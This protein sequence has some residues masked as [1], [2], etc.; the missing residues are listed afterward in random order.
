[1]KSEKKN[2]FATVFF[3][4]VFTKYR[5]QIGLFKLDDNKDSNDY[6]FNINNVK[7]IEARSN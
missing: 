5:I 1:M 7:Y 3:H 4:L 2:F 6:I